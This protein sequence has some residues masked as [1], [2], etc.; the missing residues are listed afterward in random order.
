M[1]TGRL[2]VCRCLVDLGMIGDGDM[3]LSSAYSAFCEMNTAGS[4]DGMV[5][6]IDRKRGRTDTH[7]E[8]QDN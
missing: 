5:N 2:G 3:L 4:A 1:L 7:L 8:G 6:G